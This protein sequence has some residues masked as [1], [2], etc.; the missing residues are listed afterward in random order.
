[1]SFYILTDLSSSQEIRD[2]A[3][4]KLVSLQCVPHA[5]ETISFAN[6]AFKVVDVLHIHNGIT[7]VFVQVSPN[8]A[9]AALSS[10]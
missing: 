6:T 2:A 5:G 3:G 8:K 1:M 4:S 7:R 9:A 10:K